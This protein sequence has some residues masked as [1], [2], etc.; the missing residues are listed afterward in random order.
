M[1]RSESVAAWSRR[2]SFAIVTRPFAQVAAS[3]GSFQTIVI[4]T[5]PVITSTFTVRT[6]FLKSSFARHRVGI[7]FGSLTL[8]RFAEESHRLSYSIGSRLLSW[9]YFSV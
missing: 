2:K 5:A 9:I 6:D 4:V 1:L 3:L 7:L 8:H